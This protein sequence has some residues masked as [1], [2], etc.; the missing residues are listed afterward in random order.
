MT[1]TGEKTMIWNILGDYLY[2]QYIKK[3]NPVYTQHC[4]LYLAP[5]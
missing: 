3:L 5:K 2:I 1:I 4:I